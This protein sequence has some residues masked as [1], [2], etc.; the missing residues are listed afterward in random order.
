[1]PPSE[2]DT[3]VDAYS[4][5]LTRVFTLTATLGA[6][7]ILGA[8]AVE[9]KGIKTEKS[10]ASKNAKAESGVAKSEAKD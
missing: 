6:C 4:Y 2:L 10:G 1:V 7:M 5:A 9:W 3:V 8:L